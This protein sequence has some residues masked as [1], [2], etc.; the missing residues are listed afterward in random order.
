MTNLVMIPAF[1]CDERLYAEIAPL[2]PSNVLISTVICD[3]DSM[4]RCVEQVLAQ[5][6]LKFV[7]LGTSFGGRVALEATLA[8]PDRVQGLVVIGSSPGPVADQVAGLRRSERLRA[9]EAVQ[10]ATEMGDRIAHMDGPNGPA[11]RQAFIDMCATLGPEALTR[12]SDALAK[13]SDLW[14]RLGEIAC[15]ALMLWG[16]HDKY[17]PAAEGFRMSAA[18]PN[19][20]YVEMAD[21]G[22]FPTLEYPDETAAAIDHWMEDVGLS[23][24]L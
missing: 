21:C 3:G 13:R 6:P 20:R 16:V 23:P 5:A 19:G 24:K 8:A 4:A 22:H 7:V 17:S 11:A 14:Q 9:G 2:L 15:P 12:Q 10:V 1:G 18:I